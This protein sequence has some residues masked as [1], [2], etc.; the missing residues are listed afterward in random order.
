MAFLRTLRAAV[1]VCVLGGLPIF[2][3][4]SAGAQAQGDA[5]TVVVTATRTIQ[6]IDDALSSVTI[7]TR[8]DI[9]ARQATSVQELLTGEAGIQISN[10][11]G[12]GKATALFL[13]GTDADQVLVLVD[14]IKLT[15]VTLG[16][17][18]FEYLPVEE[19]DRIEIVRGPRSSLYGSEAVGGVIL[20]QAAAATIR[21]IPAQAF[22][23]ARP[24]FPTVSRVPTSAAM[25]MRRAAAHLFLRAGVALRSISRPTAFTALRSPL[26]SDTISATRRTSRSQHC[27]PREGPDSPGRSSIMRASSSRPRA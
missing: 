16:T 3:L 1:R 2:R 21:K 6:S 25:A 27:V 13:R 22:P 17:T 11:G 26:G 23:G 4:A 14:G 10:N 7:I 20:A 19:I 15:S 8:A 12:L 9:Q 5:A 24:V 18:A